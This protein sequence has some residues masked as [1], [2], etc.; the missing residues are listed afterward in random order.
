MLFFFMAS[1][2]AYDDKY[3]YVGARNTAAKNENKTRNTDNVYHT[4]NRSPIVF[5]DSATVLLH[6][7][8]AYR[9]F[10]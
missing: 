1:I 6:L 3:E 5:T 10:V 2:H 4:Y 8:N 7:S 9:N